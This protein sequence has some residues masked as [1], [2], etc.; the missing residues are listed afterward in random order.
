VAVVAG[1]GGC[2]GGGG[3]PTTAGTASPTPSLTAA[4]EPG[5]QADVGA[6]VARLEEK[7]DSVVGLQALDTGTGRAVGHN[8]DERFAFAS[9]YKALAA[10]AVLDR[11]SPAGL[12]DVVAYDAEDLVEYSPVAERH[13]ADGMT[14]RQ[15]ID[16]AV[17]ESDNTAGNLL[18][19]EL[20]G[21]AGLQEA[22]RAL[23]DDTTVSVRY[24]PELNDVDPGDERDTS[25]ARVLAADL[26]AYA[27]GDV[28]DDDARQILVEAL[29][30][31]TTGPD[32]IR[33]GVPDGWVVGDKTGTTGNGTRNDIAVVWPPDGAP[34]VLA[35]LTRTQDPAAAPDDAL[36]AEVAGVAV[37]ALRP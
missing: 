15:I 27:L 7:Y 34:L 18:F 35:V 5:P 24:E 4:P 33:A 32:A 26:Q 8:Q 6:E 14:V 19:D 2:S 12:D 22:L 20:G 1:L 25:T 9:T 29:R 11:S 28:L 31:S 36:L 17:R 10:G 30:G 21:P 3:A 16:A 23:G 37:E 13:V